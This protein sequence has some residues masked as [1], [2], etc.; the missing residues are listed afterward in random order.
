MNVLYEESGDFKVGTVR[1]ESAASLQVEAPHGRRTKI[2]SAN[3]L[4]RFAAPAP[5]ELL[6]G[7]QG[8]AAQIDTSFLWEC[9]GDAE[10]GFADL[11][12][13]YFGH[14]PA[15]AEAAGIL[16]KLHAEP[17]HFHR[18][19]RGRFR[20]APADVLKA[21]LAGLDRK[22][23]QAEQVE[24]WAAELASFRFPEELAGQMPALLYRPDRGRLETRALD[25]ACERTGLTPAKLLE[26]CG[27]LGSSRDYHLN[28]F[29]FEHFPGGPGFPSTLAPA[30]S[31]DLPLAASRAFSLDD[32]TTTEIDDAFSLEPRADGTL[33]IGVH[34]AAPALGFAPGSDVDDVARSRLSTVYMP[35][36]KI[37]MLPREV[38]DRHT[39]AAG[40]AP[41]TV[42]L[43]LDIDAA[44]GAVRSTETR[45]ERVQIAANLRHHEVEILNSAF[46]RG[47]AAPDVTFSS[48]LLALWRFALAL[49][50]G[51]G[52]PLTNAERPEYTFAVA[53]DRVSITRRKRGAPLDKLVA[54][55][56]ILVNRTW[57]KLLDDAGFAA[58]YRVQG[59]GGKVRLATAA[60]EHF[61]L[62]V[63][64]Y[65]WASSP[66]RRYV[67]LINQWQLVAALGGAPA[68][69]AH[70]GETLLAAMRDFESAYAAYGEF[71]ERMERYW[72]LRWLLQENVSIARAEV[73]RE[74]LVRFVDI[75]LYVRVPSLP[76]ELP[77]GEQVMVEIS[78]IDLIDSDLRC[79]YKKPREV[80]LST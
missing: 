58:I 79:V 24:R 1:E 31:L 43:Y 9:C 6:A 26:R 45:V 69:F 22:R 50:A 3:V 63:S 23:L 56:M 27:A 67:D 48:E 10:F 15:P 4:L 75:P 51:R 2:K 29:L 33:R 61:G 68:P 21:A 38:V 74:G 55:L 53:A 39:L 72:C 60:G 28:R 59:A 8:V 71:Q 41:P 62:G 14:N 57:G 37:T 70:G 44:S 49:E 66:L 35:G 30:H 78:D 18:K 65:A 16:F 40:S 11:A 77:G 13:E 80:L 54:E 25:A 34:I 12:A 19:G 64:H 5:A 20:A 76:P 73:V 32:A 46:E 42:S 52:R 36:D 7:A 47:E 17:A